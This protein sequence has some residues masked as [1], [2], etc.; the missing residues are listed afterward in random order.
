MYPPNFEKFERKISLK[1]RVDRE[2]KKKDIQGPSSIKDQSQE[3]NSISINST[4]EDNATCHC[5]IQTIGCAGN[6]LTPGKELIKNNNHKGLFKKNDNPG[7]YFHLGLLL[8]AGYFKKVIDNGLEH[9]LQWLAAI[10]LGMHNIEQSK[11]L[12]YNS[13]GT[14]IGRC[15]KSPK[16]QRKFIKSIATKAETEKILKLNAQVVQI[17]KYRDFYYDPHTKHY[18]GQLKT[19]STWCPSVRLADKGINMDFIHSVDG[20][21]VYFN[22]DDNFYDL[23]ERFPGNINSFRCITS[24]PEDKTLTIIIDRGIYSMDVFEDAIKA[25]NMHIITWE[26]GYENNKWDKDA[27]TSDGH[28]RKTRNHSK[29]IKLVHYKYQEREWDKNPAM[30]QIIVRVLDKKSD[31][32]IEVS[33]LADDKKRPVREVIELMLKRWVQENDFKYLIKH[34]GINEITTYAFTDY[35]ELKDKIED[36]V[37][38]CNKHKTL[39]K[40]IQ[41]ARAKLKTALLRKHMFEQKYSCGEEK[42]T[43]QDKKRKEKIWSDM[44]KLSLQLKKLEKQRSE[45]SKYVS[46]IEELISHD[47]KKLDTNVKSYMDA[48]KIMAR[49]IFY[50]AFEPFKEQY[51][52]YRDDH[53]LFRHLSHSPGLLEKKGQMLNVKLFPK[54]EYTPKTKKAI[55][56]ILNKINEEEPIIP[57]GL[58]MKISLSLIDQLNV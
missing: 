22:S 55:R 30:R 34:F 28:I 10:L 46:K 45:T 35:K 12:N 4:G 23:R 52:N 44:D 2:C 42:I 16:N 54:M 8:Y 5:G 3:Q 21:P 27:F 19:L 11:E 58:N 31:V 13:L 1:K 20:K 33:I 51:N 26:K 17:G 48:I 9:I 56:H 57:N 53:F 47:Y 6:S 39:T 49:N 29:D 43:K 25:T 18:T 24:I 41:K 40:E 14:M 36:K 7:F 15:I 50:L 32:L 38:T 37:Y